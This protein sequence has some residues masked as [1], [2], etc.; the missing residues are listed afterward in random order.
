[1]NPENE[2]DENMSPGADP[3]H[4]LQERLAPK[5]EEVVEHLKGFEGQAREI[6]RKHPGKVLLGA[7]AVGFIVGKLA[8]RR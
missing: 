5:V 8:S 2:A 1:M 7:L 4:A 6:V 3:L